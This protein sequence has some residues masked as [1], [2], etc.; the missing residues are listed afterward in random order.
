VLARAVE[1]AMPL[2]EER[3]H[4]LAVDV[5]QGGLLVEADLAR[6][7]QVFANLLA[8][9][10]KYTEPNGRVEVTA[11]RDGGEVVVSV[12]DTGVGIAPDMLGTVF[13]LFV[14][15]E[16]P[17]DRSQGGLGVGLTVARG[18]VELHGGTIAAYSGGAGAGTE[19][20]VRLPACAPSAAA[21]DADPAR[22][23]PGALRVLVV[24]DNVDAAEVLAEA[25]RA[26]GHEVAVA[27]DGREAL[28]LA[29]SFDPDAA[30]LDIGLPGMD[31]YELAR[32]IRALAAARPPRLVALTG[33]GQ[34][35]DRVRAREAGFDVHLVKPVDLDAVVGLFADR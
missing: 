32:R 34:D 4:V 30:V 20:V 7:A 2:L 18:L 5:P 26:L 8:N 35:G 31:G 13:D 29:A 19:V 24:D 15:G 12:R 21:K 1:L 25:L 14:Q 22:S 27:H 33:Y 23:P 16:R 11:R 3:S 9:A 6:L 10:A 17:L 28:V